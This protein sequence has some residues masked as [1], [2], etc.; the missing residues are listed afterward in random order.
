MTEPSMTS[1][2]RCDTRACCSAWPGWA[3][4]ARWA[5]CSPTWCAIRPEAACLLVAMINII[6]RVADES[7]VDLDVWLDQAIPYLITQVAE[8]ARRRWRPDVL[9]SIMRTPNQAVPR[10]GCRPA[11]GDCCQHIS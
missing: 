1:H 8:P 2:P 7:N 5:S 11:W 6:N 10:P 9:V 4:P 3:T